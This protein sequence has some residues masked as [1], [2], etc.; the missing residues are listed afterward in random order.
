MKLEPLPEEGVA[1][2]PAPLHAHAEQHVVFPRLGHELSG[3]LDHGVF[4]KPDLE[5]HVLHAL[6]ALVEEPLVVVRAAPNK[7]SVFPTAHAR[8]SHAAVAQHHGH[9]TG[10]RP[11]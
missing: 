2:E 1:E 4:S 6:A 9:L 11:P 3:N 10:V 8:H 5:R 7:W